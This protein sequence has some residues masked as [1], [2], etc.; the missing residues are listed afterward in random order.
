MKLFKPETM[1][2]ISDKILSNINSVSFKEI[3]PACMSSIDITKIM[4]NNLNI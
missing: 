2:S 3:D 1:T 4:I